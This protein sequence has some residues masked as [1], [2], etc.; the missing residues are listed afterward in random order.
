MQRSTS[1]SPVP[2]L[3]VAWR[4]RQSVHGRKLNTGGDLQE[5]LQFIVEQTDALLSDSTIKRYRPDGGD[6]EPGELYA[7]KRDNRLDAALIDEL[8]RGEGLDFADQAELRQRRLTCYAI[9]KGSGSNQRIY[10]RRQDPVRL[11]SKRLFSSLM[12]G[13]L[14]ELD[15]PV[16]AF[17]E[18]IDVVIEADRVIVLNPKGF[19][20]LFRDSATVL[21]AVPQWV[22]ELRGYVNFSDESRELL[23]DAVG[24]NSLHRN[25]LLAILDSAYASQ[26]TPKIIRK[27]MKRH[28]LDHEEL[29]DGDT[30]RLTQASLGDVLKLLNEDLY[31]GDFSDEH[32]AASGK[33]PFGK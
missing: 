28:G 10:V 6:G 30:L 23:L 3:A 18:F 26:L 11:A 19:E 17:D 31:R 25:K 15:A 33:R 29:L 7:A 4:T 5:Y 14:T 32:F 24:R 2:S 20:S 27:R 16:L 9:V 21:A 13:P 1:M 8:S 22:D 12:D